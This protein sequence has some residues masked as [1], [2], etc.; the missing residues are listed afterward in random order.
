MLNDKK[1]H[2]KDFHNMSS[3]FKRDIHTQNLL[4]K[5][6]KF[7]PIPKPMENKD[8]LQDFS[9]FKRRLTVKAFIQEEVEKGNPHFTN[10]KLP[11]KFYI[12]H[13]PSILQKVTKKLIISVMILGMPYLL[14]LK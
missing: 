13:P 14:S 5:G 4:S 7:I 9:Y 12:D 3:S 8:I 10:H 11:P 1:V 6:L 2:T